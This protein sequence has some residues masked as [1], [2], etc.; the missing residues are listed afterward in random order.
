[1]GY[2]SVS[3]SHSVQARVIL[4]AF[5]FVLDVQSKNDTTYF[6]KKVS[7]EV[8]KKKCLL[9]KYPDS[10]DISLQFG[11]HLIVSVGLSCYP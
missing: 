7:L 9:Q 10:W 11:Y 8:A 1:M 6:F 2:L 3:L 4:L 5:F